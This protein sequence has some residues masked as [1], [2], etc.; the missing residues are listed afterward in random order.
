MN[1]RLSNQANCPKTISKCQ[2]GLP[3][4]VHRSKWTWLSNFGLGT[5]GVISRFLDANFRPFFSTFLMSPGKKGRCT[6][7]LVNICKHFLVFVTFF[8]PFDH[9]LHRL[10]RGG[11]HVDHPSSPGD[12]EGAHGWLVSRSR[13]GSIFFNRLFLGGFGNSKQI[14]LCWHG[15]AHTLDLSEILRNWK[16]S[17]RISRQCLHQK[18]VVDES[19]LSNSAEEDT[20]KT[21]SWQSSESIND[22]MSRTPSIVEWLIF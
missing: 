18:A 11:S 9:R 14:A 1:D 4:G 6:Q 7:P 15:N 20:T 17:R 8:T 12:F 21:S 10:N 5:Q 22:Q 3:S 19:V 2:R 13:W 16:K